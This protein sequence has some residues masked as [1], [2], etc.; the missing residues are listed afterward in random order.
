VQKE[1]ARVIKLVTVDYLNNK[2]LPIPHNSVYVSKF[3]HVRR[4]ILEHKS[5]FL[6]ALFLLASK[7]TRKIGGRVWRVSRDEP[8]V[9]Y[10]QNLNSSLIATYLGQFLGKNVIFIDHVGPVNK[11]YG[12]LSNKI[13]KDTNYI[14]V[15]DIVCLGT[16]VKVAKSL[17][18]FSGGNYVGN[19]SLFRFKTV[20]NPN[21]TEPFFSDTE[22]VLEM[23]KDNNPI[24]LKVFT[25]FN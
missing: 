11:V 22:C 2:G 23:T 5:L 8:V 19:V 18:E 4:L 17:I 25:E 3:I 1:I 20:N 10:S 16:E 24:G 15:S 9:L 21:S 13:S 7:M 14:V 12:G 6:Y